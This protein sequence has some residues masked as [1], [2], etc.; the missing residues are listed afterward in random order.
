MHPPPQKPRPLPYLAVRSGAWPGR[1]HVRLVSLQRWRW[2]PEPVGN[3]HP[4]GG[5]GLSHGALYRIRP[6]RMPCKCMQIYPLSDCPQRSND[7]CLV[8]GVS[9]SPQVYRRTWSLQM[10]M[11]TLP[12]VQHT[13]SPR[14]VLDNTPRRLGN[15]RRND[16]F[17]PNFLKV[18]IFLTA[19]RSIALLVGTSR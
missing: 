12:R 3:A 15:V 13:S 8:F 19:S 17:P 7:R 16:V 10:G 6:R 14:R 9:I 1:T 11:P 18:A 4:Q 5:H 2:I